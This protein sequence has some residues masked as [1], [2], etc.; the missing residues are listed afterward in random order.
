MSDKSLA[1]I[2]GVSEKTISRAVKTLVDKGFITRETK[3]TGSGRER[4]MKVNLDVIAATVKMTV[5]KC[6][7]S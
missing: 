5:G 1:E 7:V 2:F 4:H 6:T 3:N